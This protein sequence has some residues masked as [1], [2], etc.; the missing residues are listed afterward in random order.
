MNG[1]TDSRIMNHDLFRLS[2]SLLGLLI[3]RWLSVMH[4]S[5]EEST[6]NQMSCGTHGVVLSICDSVI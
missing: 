3:I 4:R 2:L 6:G 1:I 5:I